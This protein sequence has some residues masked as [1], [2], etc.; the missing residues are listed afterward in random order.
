MYP[1]LEKLLAVAIALIASCV[2]NAQMSNCPTLEV[3]IVAA[4]S[5]R[6][7]RQISSDQGQRIPLT[8]TPLVSL[9]DF[10]HA[11]VSLTEGQFVL[12]FE[13]NDRSAERVQAFSEANVG[14]MMVFIVN[15][16]LIR[17]PR[18]KDP[19]VGR[20]FLIGPFSREEAQGLADAVNHRGTGC[21]SPPK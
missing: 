3:S 2:M 19:I 12:N 10:T 4:N 18:I 11:D 17:T 16:R 14:K 21:D 5:E 7:A 8:A 13:M 15:G 6:A 1:R 9:R 20:G